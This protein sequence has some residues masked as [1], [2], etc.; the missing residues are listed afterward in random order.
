MSWKL[1]IE[2]A[3]RYGADVKKAE[4]AAIFH[5]YAKFRDKDEMKEIISRITWVTSF[6]TTIASYGMHLSEPIL[7]KEK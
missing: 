2:L 4:I 7:L 6:W 5:D 1:A 3:Q